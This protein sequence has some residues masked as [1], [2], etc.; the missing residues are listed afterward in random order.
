MPKCCAI[1]GCRNNNYKSGESV[2]FLHFPP[3]PVARLFWTKATGRPNWAPTKNSV[4]CS[5]HFHKN[6]FSRRFQGMRRR[7]KRGAIP[8]HTE[9]L[10]S[11]PKSVPKYKCIRCKILFGS[12]KEIE[13]HKSEA[14]STL[15]SSTLTTALTTTTLTTSSTATSFAAIDPAGS[16]TDTASETDDED[17]LEGSKRYLNSDIDG[18]RL[19]Q[20]GKNVGQGIYDQAG[21]FQLAKEIKNHL[22]LTGDQPFD[23]LGTE[24]RAEVGAHLRR[25]LFNVANGSLDSLLGSIKDSP[26]VNNITAF[27]PAESVTDTASERDCGDPLE[28]SKR[29]VNISINGKRLP[30]KS[31]DVCQSNYDQAG[32]LVKKLPFHKIF[33]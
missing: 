14:H 12:I 6:D 27:D 2:G 7:L 21:K 28:G 30:T 24:R 15:P 13:A 5:D 20:K 16:D 23:T 26:E 22:G 32:K 25:I 18:K 11:L 33:L 4:I 19:L 17:P 8:N 3:D 9:R 1:V 29:P 31:E 10:E